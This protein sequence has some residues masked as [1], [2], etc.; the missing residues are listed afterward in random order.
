MTDPAL[1]QIA[2]A[3]A[4]ARNMTKTPF[5]SDRPT[6]GTS[7]VIEGYLVRLPL[8]N[9]WAHPRG[10]PLQPMFLLMPTDLWRCRD[11][12]AAYAINHS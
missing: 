5:G 7:P 3:Q 12:V 2:A 8:D 9:R 1:D 4:D 10:V 6:S 11:C